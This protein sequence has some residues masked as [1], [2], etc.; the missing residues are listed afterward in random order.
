VTL[1]WQDALVFAVAV[2][3]VGWLVRYRA[4]RRLTSGCSDCPAGE[5]KPAAEQIIPASSIRDRTRTE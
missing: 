5:E 4:R 1:G 2:A 3:A